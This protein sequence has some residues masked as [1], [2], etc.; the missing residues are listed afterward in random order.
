MSVPVELADGDGEVVAFEGE[1]L[2]CVLSRAFAPGSPVSLK[3]LL[4]AGP[5][6]VRGKAARSRRLEDGRF[7]V[8]LRGVSL[9]RGQREALSKALPD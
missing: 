9:H 2:S 3:I 4:E 7:A 5:L 8:K 1:W 6:A